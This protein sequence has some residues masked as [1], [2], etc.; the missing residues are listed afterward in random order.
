MPSPANGG[1]APSP[2]QRRHDAPLPPFGTPRAGGELRN[3]LTSIRDT[4]SSRHHSLD[5]A[6]S[7]AHYLRNRVLAVG[8]IF[9]LLTPLWRSE[10]HTSELQS[11]PHLVC[12]L[13][14][15][16]KKKY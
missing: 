15:E 2:E 5:F 14:L 3:S 10:E 13:L 9:L 12:R 4:F 6:Y 1:R 8:M 16:K 11:R 7:H